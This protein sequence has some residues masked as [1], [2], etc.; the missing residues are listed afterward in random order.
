MKDDGWDISFQLEWEEQLALLYCRWGVLG[1]ALDTVGFLLGWSVHPTVFGTS[2]CNNNNILVN[3]ARMEGHYLWW[4]P[5][6]PSFFVRPSASLQGGLLGVQWT[7]VTGLL[8]GPVME[9]WHVF[10]LALLCATRGL[11]SNGYWSVGL[12]WLVLV[13]QSNLAGV[14]SGGEVWRWLFSHC[15]NWN[16]WRDR[17]S[18]LEQNARLWACLWLWLSGSVTGYSRRRPWWE[19]WNSTDKPLLLVD[20]NWTLIGQLPSSYTTW[21]IL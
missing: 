20:P 19:P 1:F 7:V 21:C 14:W 5:P 4:C 18:L 2:F 11:Q 8:W 3:T 16:G 10:N 6:S 9:V 17:P 15:W 12:H 13:R